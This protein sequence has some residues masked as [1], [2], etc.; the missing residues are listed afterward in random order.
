[1][2]LLHPALTFFSCRA[3]VGPG[4]RFSG[5]SAMKKS[6][7]PF[8]K[9]CSFLPA[10]LLMCTIFSFSAQTGEVSSGLSYQVSARLVDTVSSISG[11]ELSDDDREMW[12]DRIHTPV[13]K[14]AH[15]SEYCLLALFVSLPL[16]VWG[17]RGRKRFL[18]A[19]A[20][21]TAFAG[22][23]EFHQS[24]VGGRGP[25]LFDVLIDSAGAAAGCAL[26]LIFKNRR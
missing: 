18:L 11:K 1:M 2:F 14:A 10:L 24:F 6:L 16:T 21:C 23:D 13:R 7:H 17:I 5:G 12:I 8:W 19:L 22:S 15:M 25:S 3:I 26:L 9:V 4:Y 20:F